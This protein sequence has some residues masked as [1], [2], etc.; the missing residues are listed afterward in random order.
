MAICTEGRETPSG[1]EGGWQTSEGS[2]QKCMQRGEPYERTYRRR[3]RSIN[4]QAF[5]AGG[6]RRGDQGTAAFKGLPRGDCRSEQYPKAFGF[7]GETSLWDL[8]AGASCVVITIVLG[9]RCFQKSIQFQQSWDL[10]AGV[11]CMI[12]TGVS[13][14][15]ADLSCSMLWYKSSR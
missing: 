6:G 2:E 9:S 13:K 5:T 14:L 1:V 8:V 7:G 11:S 10:V 4:T 12:I 15:L 3:G